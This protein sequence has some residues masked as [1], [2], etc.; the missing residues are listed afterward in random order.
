MARDIWW[1]LFSI[2]GVCWVMPKTV[3]VIKLFF[4]WG[5]GGINK[6]DVYS[7][8]YLIQKWHKA[9]QKLQMKTKRKESKE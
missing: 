9:N 2:F 6:K 5:G 4:S 1:L 3:V 8:G 7:K